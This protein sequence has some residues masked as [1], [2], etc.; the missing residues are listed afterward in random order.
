L[1][2]VDW[3][4]KMPNQESGGELDCRLAIADW[5]SKIADKKLGMN[6]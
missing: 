6:R 2:I 4:L 3:K 5:E 1:S